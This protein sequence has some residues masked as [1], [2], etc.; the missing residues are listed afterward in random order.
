MHREVGGAVYRN[1]GGA[2]CREVGGAV[3]G[4]MGGAVYRDVG[5]AVYAGNLSS[6]DSL[7]HHHR[8]AQKKVHQTL[9]IKTSLDICTLMR[10]NVRS[11][12]TLCDS[13]VL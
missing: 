4:D 10:G 9:Q 2:V 5:G 12:I 13:F 7:S 6:F 8:S 3:Y 11:Q 1:V